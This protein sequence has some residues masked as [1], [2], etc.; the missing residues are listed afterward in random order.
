MNL[1]EVHGEGFAFAYVK[2]TQG[3][4]YVDPYYATWAANPGGLH[5]IPYHY[6][7]LEDGDAQMKYLRHIVGPNVKE[8]MLDEETGGARNL[9]ELTEHV[10]AA[11]TE[12]FDAVDL[13]LP[14]WRWVEIGSP[15]LSKLRIRYL[16]ASDYPTNAP[17]YASSLY[18]GDGFAGWNQYGN[19][20]PD[21]L[22]FTSNAIVGG[23]HVDADA[24]D[25]NVV[26]DTPPTVPKPPQHLPAIPHGWVATVKQVQIQLNRWPFS[27]TLQVDDD[28]GV[29][30]Q[31]AIIVFQHAAEIAD[32]GVVGPVTWQK[33]NLIYDTTRPQ[34]KQ[35][36]TGSA[37]KW[38][39]TRLNALHGYGLKVDGNFGHLTHDAV[40]HFQT[41][42][43]LKADGVAGKETNAA[44]QL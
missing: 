25:A 23:Q 41:S 11:H 39:Q 6:C 7:T 15:D 30:T 8:C 18:P 40:V 29:H 3:T 34:L 26:W 35:G 24:A 36:N 22:Q 16:I 5:E 12:E 42:A 44:L 17:G 21:I 4:N 13:Y 27:P 38:L 10:E 33:L 19:K 32:D 14:H 31:H 1:S 43:E 20:K 37:V 2:A 9:A 28:L